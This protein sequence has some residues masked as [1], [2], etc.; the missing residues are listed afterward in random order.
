MSDVTPSLAPDEGLYF[1]ALRKLDE[2]LDGKIREDERRFER[3][4][5]KAE[6]TDGAV[7]TLQTEV[8]LHRSQIAEILEMQISVAKSAS[9]A[10]ELSALALAKSSTSSDDNRK[11]VESAM[12]IHGSAIAA[13]VT[14]AVRPLAVE[15]EDLKKNDKTQNESLDAIGSGIKTLVRFAGS[16][17]IAAYVTIGAIVGGALM[18]IAKEVFR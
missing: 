2:R 8:T 10:A 18:A 7:H 9:V 11:M 16:K 3:I 15:V 5:A 1:S 14:S 6:K 12:A 17:R 13:A 4:E